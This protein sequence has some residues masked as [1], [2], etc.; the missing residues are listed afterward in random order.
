MYVLSIQKKKRR[1]SDE[2]LEDGL[3]TA[4]LHTNT[5]RELKVL[6]KREF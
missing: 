4:I 3:M 6:Q 2:L 1:Q 5:L